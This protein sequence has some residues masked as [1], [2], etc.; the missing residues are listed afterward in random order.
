MTV[1]SSRRWVRPV[2]G[3]VL[4]IAWFAVAGL[5]GPYFGRIDEVAVNDQAS[6]LPS[7]AEST[8]VQK[9]LTDF[10]GGDTIP[11]VVVAE[12]AGGLT[13]EDQ[14]WLAAQS[15]TLPEQVPAISGGVSP[16]LPSADGMAAQIFVPLSTSADVTVAV[17]DLR[18]SLEGAPEA[19]RSTSPV[20]RD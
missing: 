16:A 15:A 13:I 9:R 10:F 12:R 3:L 2:V 8:Q 18:A 7:S 19:S 1:R 5:G 4:T 17:A 11:A 6:Y 14:A 20:R